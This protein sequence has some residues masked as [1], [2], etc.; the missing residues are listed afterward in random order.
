MLSWNIMLFL[1]K[2]HMYVIIEQKG[3]MIRYGKKSDFEKVGNSRSACVK[4]SQIKQSLK[5]FGGECAFTA[6]NPQF[7]QFFTL[8]MM[9]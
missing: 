5:K 6:R 4:E 9:K 8:F 1:R 2:L 7:L 3:G